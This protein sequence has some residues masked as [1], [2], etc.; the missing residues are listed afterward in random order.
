MNTWMNRHVRAGLTMGVYGLALALGLWPGPWKNPAWAADQALAATG[1]GLSKAAVAQVVG[2]LMEQ[3]RALEDEAQRKVSG[4]GERKALLERAVALLTRA[5]TLCPHHAEARVD[6]GRVLSDS[7]L[8]EDGVRRSARELYRA[9]EDDP[10]RIFEYEISQLLGIVLSRLSLFQKAVDEYDRTQ[11]CLPGQPGSPM[12]QRSQR[13]TIL[14]NSAEALMAMGRLSGAIERYSQAEAMD[15]TDQAALHSLGLAVAYDRD[16]Q[17]EKSR[18]ALLRSLT[19]DPAL[20]LFQSDAVFFVPSG[21]RSY[22]LGLL[23]EAFDDRETALSSWQQFLKELPQSRYAARARVHLETLRRTPGLSAME[24]YR[25]EVVIGDPLFPPDRQATQLL[26]KRIRSDEDIQRT[27]QAHRLELRQ[28]YAR[29]L[30]KEPRLT[31]EIEVALVLERG[32]S[33][34]LAE[35]IRNGFAVDASAG[36]TGATGAGQGSQETMTPAAR[37][38]VHCAVDTLR[39]WRFPSSEAERDELAI[40]LLFEARK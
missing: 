16:G 10:A 27:A 19:T 5:L 34:A 8:G 40:P 2:D 24:L 35:V 4:D 28:C 9:R 31:G 1:V 37:E 20:K 15:G 23:S 36:A 3:A 7:E 39:R 14:G 17:I 29:S 32:G 25:A 21:D 11:Q 13:A 6:L 12:R 22:Y 38:L 30:R 18:D 26:G 33:V